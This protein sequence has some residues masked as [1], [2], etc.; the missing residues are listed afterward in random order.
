MNKIINNINMKIQ[1][2]WKKESKKYLTEMQKLLDKLENI[3]NEEL[4]K[5]III[6]ILKC[7]QELTKLAEKNLKNIIIRGKN[8]KTNINRINCR[9]NQWSICSRRRNDSSSSIN[10]FI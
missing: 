6:Q 1:E 3:E 10:S 4:R 8:V 7:D 2:D 5:E 9:N